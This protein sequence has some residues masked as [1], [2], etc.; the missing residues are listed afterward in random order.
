L[1]SN[2]QENNSD[3][4][5]NN[6]MSNVSSQPNFDRDPSIS[7]NQDENSKKEEHTGKIEDRKKYIEKWKDPLVIVTIV[8]AFATFMLY[9]RA[10][11]ESKIAENAVKAAQDEVSEQ[12]KE[13][14][15]ENAALV[16]IDSV[17]V[18][19][20]VTKV[21]YT[22]KMVNIGKTPAYRVQFGNIAYLS[23][24]KDTIFRYESTLIN[25][26][27]RINPIV[28]SPGGH[29]YSGNDSITFINNDIM[30]SLLKNDNDIY[31][32]IDINYQDIFG[33]NHFTHFFAEVNVVRVKV[34]LGYYIIP[35][36]SYNSIK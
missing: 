3:Q 30:S 35:T 32:A 28:I 12:K 7:S 34:G 5:F 33:K 17:N 2:N 19:N 36:G 22:F 14:Q 20:T 27:N 16:T 9:W 8:L 4:Q 31:I 6:E 10:T 15:D 24:A 11:Q 29:I 26:T 1:E 25:A 18:Y 21:A 13:F 23:F